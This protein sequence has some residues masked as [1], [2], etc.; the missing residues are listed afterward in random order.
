LITG[1]QYEPHAVGTHRSDPRPASRGY[2]NAPM[3]NPTNRESSEPN[4]GIAMRPGI[5]S[6]TDGPEG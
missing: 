4:P 6:A 1:G 2:S 5:R 3:V